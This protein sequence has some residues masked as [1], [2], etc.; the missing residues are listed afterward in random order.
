M[1][2]AYRV[3]RKF[4][5]SCFNKNHADLSINCYKST[6]QS[7]SLTV[8]AIGHTITSG[9]LINHWVREYKSTDLCLTCNDAS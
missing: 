7:L 2:C 9:K 8:T 4:L 1:N 3:P 6:L 5:I